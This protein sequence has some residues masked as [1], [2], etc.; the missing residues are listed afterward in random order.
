MTQTEIALQLIQLVALILPANV[1]LLQVLAK[2]F[3]EPYSLE[4]QEYVDARNGFQTMNEI[5]NNLTL[6]S[7]TDRWQFYGPKASIHLFLW[8]GLCFILSL[9][10]LEYI[11]LFR[12]AAEP[13]Q[14]LGIV[15]LLAGFIFMGAPLIAVKPTLTDAVPKFLYSA[16]EVAWRK[17]EKGNSDVDDKSS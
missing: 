17:T 3:E 11:A 12:I 15:M 16:R 8:A 9:L 10:A 6:R 1:I 4:N 14:L 2:V 7:N 5:Q 13:L